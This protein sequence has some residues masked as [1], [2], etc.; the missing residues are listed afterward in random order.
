MP[1]VHYITAH[2]PLGCSQAADMAG[3]CAQEEMLNK[4][5]EAARK[6]R[7][8]AEASATP[9][10]RVVLY[11]AK[12]E[13][14][15][16]LQKQEVGQPANHWES[17]LSCSDSLEYLQRFLLCHLS[18]S[19][20][21]PPARENA[22]ISWT[23]GAQKWRAVRAHVV[24]HD[25]WHSCN[26]MMPVQQAERQAAVIRQM[27]ARQLEARRKREMRSSY[28]CFSPS[29]FTHTAAGCRHQRRHASKPAQCSSQAHL[30]AQCVDSAACSVHDAIEHSNSEI[31]RQS[32][33][34]GG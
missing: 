24:A 20:A 30:K 11:A 10:E 25:A 18:C 3:C 16:L 13:R 5:A 1:S 22:D 31:L 23:L 2:P 34:D 27:E 32:P 26:R 9:E 29:S 6:R 33:G 14:A 17:L 19:P 4:Q 7:E 15:K 28:R 8:A 12:Q 21:C